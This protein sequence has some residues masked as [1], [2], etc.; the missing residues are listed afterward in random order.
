MHR[1]L[2]TACEH[3]GQ[4]GGGGRRRAA[5]SG[6]GMP[7]SRIATASSKVPG[8]QPVGA[9]GGED[10]R[11]L[12]RPVAVGVRLDGRDHGD[13]RPQP[14]G[15][16]AVVRRE[17]PEIDLGPGRT[18]A[19]IITTY[20]ALLGCRGRISSAGAGS[21]PPRSHARG[22]GRLTRGLHRPA[23]RRSAIRA[24]ELA[25]R[26]AGPAHRRGPAPREHG[27]FARA[28]LEVP[29]RGPGSQ[30]PPRDPGGGLLRPRGDVH[31]AARRRGRAVRAA[32]ALD[33]R[34]RASDD[35]Q[36]HERERSGGPDLDL[37]RP[38]RDSAAEILEEG[39]E[40][41]S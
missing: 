35:A 22:E 15:E 1:G 37:R 39:L 23:S 9:L 38:R 14:P 21:H 16:L 3:V 33:R 7:A 5:G 18:R 6:V 11:D 24:A 8:G 12:D 30:A 20:Q 28:P 36:A 29:G 41:R 13:A 2:E 17:R 19:H 31:D 40:A 25:P 10:A 4:R 27:P 34:G 26:G 32:A